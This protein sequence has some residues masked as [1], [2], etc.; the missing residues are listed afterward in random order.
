MPCINSGTPAGTGHPPLSDISLIRPD[1]SL[2]QSERNRL[3]KG[4]GGARSGADQVMWSDLG[5]HVPQFS[6]ITLGHCWCRAP[7]SVWYISLV[8]PDK[9]PDA[10][11]AQ[12]RLV[13]CVARSGADHVNRPNLVLVQ[14]KVESECTDGGDSRA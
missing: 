10:I 1:K 8:R 4:G 2:T 3:V 14:S 6:P 7:T 11:G 12:S 9:E 5:L 13:K